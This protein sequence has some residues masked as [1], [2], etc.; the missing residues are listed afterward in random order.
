MIQIDEDT[1]LNWSI[2][3]FGGIVGFFVAFSAY[4]WKSDRHRLK[5]MEEKVALAITRP[6]VELIVKRVEDNVKEQHMMLLG[7]LEKGHDE[8]R[9]DIRD[10]RKDLTGRWDGHNRRGDK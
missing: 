1:I 7:V 8:L 4:I 9:Q 3:I 2:K 5:V 10:L 6:E